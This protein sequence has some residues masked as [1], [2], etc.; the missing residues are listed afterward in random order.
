MP[1]L[2]PRTRA[3][4][5][6]GIEE[7]LHLGGQLY[8]A[9]GGTILADLALG[10]D[11][12]GQA[13]STDHLMLWLSSSKPVAAVAVAQLLAPGPPELDDRAARHIP[14]VARGRKDA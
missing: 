3:L 8:V 4:L 10:E 12:P 5:E 2:L 13:L 9:R 6:R 11:R 14:E 7:R 1:E